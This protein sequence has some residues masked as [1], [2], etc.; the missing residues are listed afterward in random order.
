MQNEFAQFAFAQFARKSFFMPFNYFLLKYL[1][2]TIFF[3][4]M[5][6]R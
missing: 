4:L 5:L 6:S 1:V 3:L 2:V